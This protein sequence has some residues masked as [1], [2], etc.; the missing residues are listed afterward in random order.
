M[1]AERLGIAVLA[2]GGG[3]EHRPLVEA[4][5]ARD[6]P[7][8]AL[9][10]VHNPAEPGE[11]PPAVPP[12]C[13]L[14]QAER[15]LGYAGGMNLG[16]ASL[17]ARGVDL[18]LLLTHDARLREGALESLLDAARRQRSYGILAPALVLAGTGTPFSFGGITR[19]TGTNAHIRARPA[20]AEGGVAPCDWVDG[21]TM[22]V[23]REVLDRVGGFDERFWGY[24][25]EADLCLRARR[26]GA[27]VGVVLAA[28]AEQ[29]PGGPKR[30]GAWAYLLTR[31]GTEYARRAV[32]GRGVTTMVLRTAWTAAHEWTR[33]L[34]LGLGLRP[35]AP[36]EP[37]AVAIGSVR[38][39]LDFFRGRWGPPPGDLPGMGDL[40]NA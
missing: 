36:G 21:G 20:A 13:E 23:R 19:D 6:V 10:I 9:L 25:E 39:L 40:H 35:G 7:F 32:G 2:Y 4:L 37:R 17:R 5:L 1:S 14:V 24:F 16:L 33:A 15:N 11:R 12:G 31:N 27:G 3:G 26:S 8:A 28:V 22:L 38:G 29:A 30:P 18:L 34:V